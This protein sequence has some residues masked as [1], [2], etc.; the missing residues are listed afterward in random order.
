M[1]WLDVVVAAALVLI[2]AGSAIPLFD[3]AGRHL[4]GAAAARYVLFAMRAARVQAAR[5]ASA[6]GVAVR[7]A[8]ESTLLQVYLDGDGDGLRAADIADGTDPP[9]GPPSDLQQEF[10]GVVAAIRRP[11][12][13]IDGSATLAPGS[14][15]VRL[16]INDIASFTPDGTASGGTV[17]LAGPDGAAYA[18]RVL[19]VTGRTRVLRFN[20]ASATW[21]EP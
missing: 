12:P 17:Y 19:A 11:L 5:R 2:L 9:L 10:R 16:G 6:V 8:G 13:E 15:P 1:V 20:P 7:V 14:D 4:R 18:I 3:S 21:A